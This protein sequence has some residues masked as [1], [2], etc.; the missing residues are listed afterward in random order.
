MKLNKNDLNKA[1]DFVKYTA[2]GF[3]MMAIIA[4]GVWGGVEADKALNT[5]PLFTLLLSLFSVGIALYHALKD[6]I[7]MDK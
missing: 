7:K 5:T 4:L 1:N 2:I 6:F 3:Q